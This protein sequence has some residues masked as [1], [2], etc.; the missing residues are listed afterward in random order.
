[1]ASGGDHI[2]LFGGAGND[3]L[4]ADG[5]REVTLFGGDGNDS[6]A[7]NAGQDITLFGG[8]G[9]DSL[10]ANG[11]TGVTL[12]GGDGNDSLVA[13][14]GTEVTLFGGTGDD[15]LAANGGRD[16]TLFGGDG[17]DSLVANGGDHITLFG[18]AG[19]DSLAA[20]GGSEVT[21]FG[22][23]GNDS[24]VA[25]AGSDITLFGGTGDDSLAAEGGTEVT[26][27]GG[28]GN[29]LLVATAGHDITLFGNAGNDS[30]TAEGGTEVTLFGG[31]G[32]D[33]LTA[34]GGLDVTLFGDAGNDTLRASDTQ[35]YRALL[36]PVNGTDVI[37]Q[38]IMPTSDHY[39]QGL[40]IFVQPVQDGSVPPGPFLFITLGTDIRGAVTTTAEELVNALSSDSLASSLVG[41]TVVLAGSPGTGLTS[42]R[43]APPGVVVYGGAGDDTLIADDATT[44]LGE[45]GNDTYRFTRAADNVTLDEIPMAG[46]VSL[47]S[48]TLDFSALSAVTIN[49]GLSAAQAVTSTLTVTLLGTFANVIGTPGN[50]LLAGN[51][52]DNLLVGGAGDD[53]LFGGAGNDTLL[54][55]SGN[56][57]I[58]LNSA[59]RLDVI[60]GGAG[61]N[62]L[63]LSQAPGLT[64]QTAPVSVTLFG[65]TPT[66][67]VTDG[68]G[69]Y[70]GTAFIATATVQ[71]V[72]GP[73]AS[74]LEGVTP[75]LTYYV[76]S[77]TTGMQL[78]GA[79]T[80]A[81]TYTVVATF[82]GSP[83]YSAASTSTTFVISPVVLTVKANDASKVYGAALPPLTPSYSG[84]VS[85][86]SAA[87]LTTPPTLTT[88]ATVT[89]P[90]GSYSITVSGAAAANYTLTYVSG[91]LTVTAAP[92]SVGV[93]AP[94]VAAG[95]HG[96]VTVT[97][98]A[99]SLMPT[100]TITLTVDGGSAL[101]KPLVSGAATFD[102]GILNA[103]SH[104]LSAGYAAQG[105]FLPSSATGTLTVTPITT[106]HSVYV[107]NTTAAAAISLSGNASLEI[108]GVL[109]V[110]SNSG[111]AF[112]ISGN[113]HVSASSINVVGHVQKSGNASL[114]T[115]PVTIGAK[116][117]ADPLAGLAIP[118]DLVFCG[119][120]NLSGNSALTIN[121]GIYGQI[122]V[123]GNARLTLKPGTYAIAGGGFT[124]TGNAQVSGSGILLYNAGSNYPNGTGGTFG[125]LTFGGNGHIDLAPAAG[126]TYAGILIFQSRDNLRALS[127]SG[128]AILLHGGTIYAPSALL[129]VSGNA[130]VEGSL[131]VNQLTL[132]GNAASTLTAAGSGGSNEANSA[133]Q[134]LAGDLVV[135]VDNSAGNLTD[136]TLAR[137]HNAIAAIN[138]VINPF[139]VN[140]TEVNDPA[141]ATTVLQ[142]AATS[143]VGGAAEGVLGCESAGYVTIVS[144]WNW[145]TGTD[146][147]GVGAGQY[148]FQTIV[149]HELG[150]ALGL[151]HSTNA[152][153]AMY[154]M[155]GTG[156]ARRVLS[157]ADLAIPDA[158]AGP[159]GLH[160]AG[161]VPVV[162]ALAPP[163][164][165]L[166]PVAAPGHGLL[167]PDLPAPASSGTQAPQVLTGPAV[168]VLPGAG[169]VLHWSETHGTE[170]LHGGDGGLVLVGGDGDDVLIGGDGRDMLVGGIGS[171]RA[172]EGSG[173]THT[174]EA[175]D[176]DTHEAALRTVL[177]EWGSGD[178][179][180]RAD[181]D[182]PGVGL[183]GDAQDQALDGTARDL[184]PGDGDV[185]A[186]LF[187][188]VFASGLG[189]DLDLGA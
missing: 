172:G 140:I 126:G 83:D 149:T 135:Y 74:S 13:N 180:R 184:L 44:L 152:S 142:V 177:H 38:Y 30:L 112:T 169:G 120:V 104:S 2:T 10:A 166:D 133:G 158:E 144:G 186:A 131:V 7:A 58:V 176:F 66:V 70:N 183:A 75:T 60:D 167:S 88:S 93:T 138:A 115:T 130:K 57:L 82:I 50:D 69:T 5:G 86:E 73:A 145:Y 19:N 173:A 168:T 141:A 62:R 85:G 25:H 47:G 179:G 24:L 151:G 165:T 81:G 41:A 22:G 94:T 11:G 6:L 119:S 137:I 163:A 77:D 117:V 39:G 116:A 17:N 16:V 80:A 128:N 32:N 79:P 29:D 8:A 189:G 129:S 45:E 113:A 127:L 72:S 124:V 181:G 36:T 54:G 53:T 109:D 136:E 156:E 90:V 162:N 187:A 98:S 34:T 48:D 155:L 37:V 161:T 31:D 97:V 59:S 105:N 100:G 87:N 67:T 96:Q 185:F 108:T 132:T 76:G 125:G 171:D 123:S 46:G 91:T 154:A 101:S 147:G 26:L 182:L 170:A 64:L 61:M 65:A 63:D 99:G 42:P 71:G 102:V 89:S 27:F 68:G 78:S 148:D 51:A 134:L 56:D 118:T 52:A 139:G 20:D 103:G 106:G 153:S 92:T 3:S 159:C 175:S 114:G 121:P 35:D 178:R 122:S 18:G 143:A 188:E 1:M 55:G 95:Q 15:S 150:H 14:A 21:L 4:A 23:D 12:F 164:A 49:L 84:F 111:T 146:A 40:Q 107:L 174:V 160:A 28:D 9:D 43:L 33:I 157:V 110:N